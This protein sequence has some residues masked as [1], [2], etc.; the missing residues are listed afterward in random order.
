MTGAAYA[1][2][3]V[4]QLRNL[5]AAT[6]FAATSVAAENVEIIILGDSLTA[7]Y[8]LPAA[9]GFVP[10]MQAWLDKAGV[11]VTLVNAGVSGDTTA[12]GLSRVDWMLTPDIDAMVVALGGNDYLR[13]LDPAVSRENLRGILDKAMAADLDVLLIGI[14]AGGN[15]GPDYQD[16]FNSMYTELAQ[17]Y[18]VPLVPT[19]FQG[20]IEAVETQDAV[21]SYM[22]SD[23]IHPNASGVGLIVSSLGP[24][25]AALAKTVQD[26]E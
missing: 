22:Q 7:G 2:G 12:G 25:F 26:G 3:A 17:I 18:D 14:T 8:G 9:D 6:V 1:Y 13:G 15:Y 10:Q 16:D 20:V 19:F 4:L 21:L 24:Q 23:G 5:A 11:Q